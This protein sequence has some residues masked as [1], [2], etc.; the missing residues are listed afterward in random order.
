MNSRLFAYLLLLGTSIIWGVAGPILKYSFAYISPFEFLFWRFLLAC[1]VTLPIM[2]WY[3]KKHPL[4]T[5]DYV[6]LFILGLLCTTINLSLLLVGLSKTTVIEATLI[7]SLTPLLVVVFSSF[8]LHEKI[9]RRMRLGLGLALL[10]STFTIFQP[11]LQGKAFSNFSGNL[12]LVLGGFAWVGFV[13]LSKKWEHPDLKPFHIVSFSFFVGLVSFFLITFFTQSISFSLYSIPKPVILPI[14]YMAVFSSLVAYTA[15]EIAISKINASQAD[16]F[17]YLAAVW[18]I[19]LA[20][21]W[22]GEKFD[23]TLLASSLLILVGIIIA[24]YKKG[25]FNSPHRVRGS[26]S[27]RPSLDGHHLAH[28]K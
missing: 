13:L 7:G 17:G 5:H 15:Y 4:K 12:L 8:F 19:P 3:F 11:L 9:S 14:I 28:H 2:F 23:L 26:V 22:L 27:A 25:L 6:K 10:G 21:I 20:I 16:P 24:E 1:V 18:S